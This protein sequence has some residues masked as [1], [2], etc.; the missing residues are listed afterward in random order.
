MARK[1]V[2]A[3]GWGSRRE[4]SQGLCHLNPDPSGVPIIAQPA[5]CPAESPH[6]RSKAEPL[7]TL[8][9]RRMHSAHCLCRHQA[10]EKG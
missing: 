3:E 5:L 4:G 10:K 2:L 8:I 1:G 9:C 7:S 6:E